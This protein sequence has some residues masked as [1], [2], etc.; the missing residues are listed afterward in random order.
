MT[1]DLICGHESAFYPPLAKTDH[2]MAA[3]AIEHRFNGSP[4]EDLRARWSSPGK[5]SAFVATFHLAE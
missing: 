5:R 1:S 4:T 3:V 2:A